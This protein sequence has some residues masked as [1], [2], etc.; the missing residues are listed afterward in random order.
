M[1]GSDP[2]VLLADI[3]VPRGEKFPGKPR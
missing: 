1:P 3:A 2:R